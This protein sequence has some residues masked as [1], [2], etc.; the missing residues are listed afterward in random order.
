MVKR[1]YGSTDSGSGGNGG[2]IQDS[3]G[4]RKEEIQA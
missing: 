4:E 1:Q 3:P 2:G